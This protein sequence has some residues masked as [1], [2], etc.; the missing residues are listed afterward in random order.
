MRH[1]EVAVIVPDRDVKQ[2]YEVLCDFERYP[3]YSPE[4]RSVSV[5]ANNGHKVSSWETDFRGGILR[6]RE[7][8]TFDP[9]AGTIGFEQIEGDIEHFSGRWMIAGEGTGSLIRFS[10]QFDMGIPSLSSIIDPIA[11]QA[12]RENI[13][14][15]LKGLFG[16]A[17]EILPP[18][19]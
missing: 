16:P 6:W 2:T 10:A 15:I 17:V 14:A 7:I 19:A 13:I 18:V 1:L 5:E 4:V 9:D 12:L 8:D 11:E 3:D